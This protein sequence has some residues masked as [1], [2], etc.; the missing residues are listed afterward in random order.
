MGYCKSAKNLRRLRR[1]HSKKKIFCKELT[2]SLFLTILE[3]IQNIISGKLDC[4]PRK[5]QKQLKEQRTLIRKLFDKKVKLK[6]RKKKFVDSS[7]SFQN[8]MMTKVIP[9]FWTTCVEDC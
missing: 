8:I 5:L 1:A 6:K 9:Q 3:I 7:K 4:F 2:D